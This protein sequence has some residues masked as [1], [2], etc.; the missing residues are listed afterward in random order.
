[1]INHLVVI[2]AEVQ[3]LQ[4]FVL[5]RLAVADVVRGVRQGGA[6]VGGGERVVPRA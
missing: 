3:R 5:Q 4:L 2:M 1:M 6:V